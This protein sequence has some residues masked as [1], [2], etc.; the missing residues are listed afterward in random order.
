M[1]IL[2]RG[3][4]IRRHRGITINRHRD[5][6]RRRVLIRRRAVITLRHPVEAIPHQ[7]TI[8]PRQVRPAADTLAAGA[9]VAAV[10]QHL[11]LATVLV[12]EVRTTAEAAVVVAEL[13]TDVTNIDSCQ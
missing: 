12:A 6:I 9:A 2:R 13:L 3:L 4:I 5:R 8:T 7:A 10:T 11:R 1:A